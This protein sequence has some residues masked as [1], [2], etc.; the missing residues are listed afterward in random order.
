MA[1]SQL[2]LGSGG[3][4]RRKKIFYPQNLKYDGFTKSRIFGFHRDVRLQ[5]RSGLLLSILCGSN[6]CDGA[7]QACPSSP[8]IGT[9]AS[10]AHASAADG[11]EYQTTGRATAGLSL[12]GQVTTVLRSL[13]GRRKTIWLVR[14]FRK[15][16]GE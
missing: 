6:A 9:T 8:R 13:N 11:S 7:V 2:D 15:I 1:L 3:L 12:R 5:G 10:F 14:K 16:F 4:L